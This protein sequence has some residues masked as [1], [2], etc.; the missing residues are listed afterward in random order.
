MLSRVLFRCVTVC[1][2]GRLFAPKNM[3]KNPQSRSFHHGDVNKNH[4]IILDYDKLWLK[5]WRDP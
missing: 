1:D 3:A 4:I 5:S 2:F